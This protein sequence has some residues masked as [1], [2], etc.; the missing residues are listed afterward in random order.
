MKHGDKAKKPAKAKGA[1]TKASRKVGSQ[2]KPHSKTPSKSSGSKVSGKAAAPKASIPK[3][4]G[5]NGKTLARGVPGSINFS[6]PLV[7]A[8]FKRAVKKYPSA[9]RRL[10]D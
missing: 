7:A 6:N 8:A 10:T 1:G 4:S 9:F 5:G 3:P 2:S